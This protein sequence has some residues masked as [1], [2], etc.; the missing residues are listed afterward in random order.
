M[1]RSILCS[2]A[3]FSPPA[4]D[5]TRIPATRF[6][7]LLPTDPDSGLVFK[8]HS[9]DRRRCHQIC[10]SFP[11]HTFLQSP[12]ICVREAPAWLNGGREEK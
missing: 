11:S 4:V 3:P 1:G 10:L 8:S 6:C 9:Q 2:R 7:S 5:P 12:K